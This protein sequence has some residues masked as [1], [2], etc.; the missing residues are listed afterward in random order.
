MTH[1]NDISLNAKLT[2]Q[3]AQFYEQAPHEEPEPEEASALPPRG[4]PRGKPFPKGT[5]GNPFGRVPGSRNN[6]TRLA[7]ALFDARAAAVSDRAIE[8]ALEGNGAALKFCLERILPRQ[9][10]AAVMVDL[11]PLD[12]IKDCSDA[13]ATVIATATAGEITLRDAQ[14]LIAMI[15]SH[16]DTIAT[17]EFDRRITAVEQAAANDSRY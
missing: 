5:S 1:E 11:P 13:I 15:E 16:C 6:A 9:R 4:L 2:A 17:Q 10:E 12:T 7:Q 14:T 3:M 8:L